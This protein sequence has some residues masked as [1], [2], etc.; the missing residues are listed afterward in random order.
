VLPND[1]S[2]SN[3]AYKLYILTEVQILDKT[4]AD[5]NEKGENSHDSYKKRQKKATLK[6]IKSTLYEEKYGKQ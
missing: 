6:R 4:T 1:I 5:N 3:Y 2:F